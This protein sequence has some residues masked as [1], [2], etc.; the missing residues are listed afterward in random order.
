VY[1]YTHMP[2]HMRAMF[3]IDEMKTMTVHPGFSF[4]KGAPVMKIACTPNPRFTAAQGG[5]DLMFDLVNDP[6][7]ESP[8]ED[9]SKKQ[10]LLD[11]MT[12]IFHE[13]EA[14]E[15]AYLRYDLKQ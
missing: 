15:E 4:T 12:R 8:I 2:T 5:Q 3:T 7:Q 14:P 1:E 13:N 11:A 6:H 9:A 10:E